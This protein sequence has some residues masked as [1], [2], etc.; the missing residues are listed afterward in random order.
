MQQKNNLPIIF[1]R[2]IQS[3]KGLAA[4]GLL[5]PQVEHNPHRSGVSFIKFDKDDKLVH[6]N[7]APSGP[8]L[9]GKQ[10]AL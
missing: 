9:E 10:Y 3:F 4:A 7:Y 6:P 5:G 8:T 1:F 2:E